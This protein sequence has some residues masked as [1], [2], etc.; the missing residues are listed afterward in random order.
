MDRL[1]WIALAV[2]VVVGA[3]YGWAGFR[4]WRGRRLALKGARTL[5]QKF[6]LPHP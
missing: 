3:D 1:L 6:T 2:G 5:T 4:D